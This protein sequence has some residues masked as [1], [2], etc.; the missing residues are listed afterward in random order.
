MLLYLY[1]E[2]KDLTSEVNQEMKRQLR[3]SVRIRDTLKR[4]GPACG[5]KV[6]KYIPPRL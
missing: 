4:L 5:K 3:N 2:A 6:K 1:P